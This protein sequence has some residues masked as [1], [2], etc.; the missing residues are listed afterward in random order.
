[1]AKYI[2]TIE[3][4]EDGS[5]DLHVEETFSTEEVANLALPVPEDGVN[6]YITQSMVLFTEIM[7][8][9]QKL[10]NASLSARDNKEPNEL[11]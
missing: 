8:F 7:C 5:A 11:H 10:A 6:P 4:L 1:M 3:D 2:I 9:V